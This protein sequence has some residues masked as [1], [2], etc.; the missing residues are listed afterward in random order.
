MGRKLDGIVDG[1]KMA[2][3]P[4]EKI[5]GDT[6]NRYYT[7][8][9][10]ETNQEYRQAFLVGWGLTAGSILIINKFKYSP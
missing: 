7:H 5:K 9:L 3:V 1:I 6:R 4:K 8:Q 10:F 2:F